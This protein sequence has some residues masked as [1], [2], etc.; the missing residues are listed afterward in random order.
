[1]SDQHHSHC[2]LIYII[3]VLVI[4]TGARGQ[5]PPRDRLRQA[6]SYLIEGRCDLAIG[7]GQ[8]GLKAHSLTV[9]DRARGLIVLASCY[10]DT[11][12]FQAAL[13][14]YEAAIELVR[15]DPSHNQE[16][17]TALD[18]FADLY[19]DMG[20]LKLAENLERRSLLLFENAQSIDG[21]ANA[22]CHIAVI[23]L[24]LNH[25]GKARSYLKKAAT[26][27]RTDGDFD[28][29]S[30]ASMTSIQGWLSQKEGDKNGAIS[31]YKYAL[32]I[33]KQ[34]HGENDA[35][36][37]WGYLLLGRAYE[38]DDDPKNALTNVQTG[39]AILDRTVGRDNPKYLTGEIVYSDIL[40]LLGSHIQA[41]QLRLDARRS[42]AAFYAHQCI[43]CR[44]SATARR[45]ALL[46][47]QP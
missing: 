37:G 30:L 18:G 31:N 11:G 38:V 14:S 5:T 23:E 24:T 22:Y 35:R 45:E 3:F 15:S 13:S 46:T 40:D 29:D 6:Y 12:K 9:S 7:A 16:Y 28:D 4:L 36:T 42:L 21:I 34:V 26:A 17:A 41:S 20:D 10:H 8:N 19:R 2:I 33:W 27:A 1:M 32:E 47:A 44:D 43:N 25:V 39:L